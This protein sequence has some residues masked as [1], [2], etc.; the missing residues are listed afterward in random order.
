MGQPAE[1]LEGYGKAETK[2]SSDTPTPPLAT[3][4]KKAEAAPAATAAANDTPQ[5]EAKS[6]G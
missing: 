1:D 3:E 2:P 4:E 5:T 6:N